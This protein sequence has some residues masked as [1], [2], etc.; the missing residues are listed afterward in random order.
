MNEREKKA[1]SIEQRAT[2]TREKTE[3]KIICCR[4]PVPKLLLSFVNDTIR[5]PETSLVQTLL[6]TL[7][8]TDLK[9]NEGEGHRERERER[10]RERERERE[11]EL[12]LIHI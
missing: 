10:K 4:T 6:T 7:L 1:K 5:D 8:S 11:R 2:Q 3:R 12:S 9:V